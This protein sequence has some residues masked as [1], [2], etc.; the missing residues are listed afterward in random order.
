MC[1]ALLFAVEARAQVAVQDDSGRT[2][3]LECP[4]RRVIALYGAFNE[5]LAAMGLDDRIVART[6]ADR[7]PPSIVGKPTIGTHMRPNIERVLGYKPDLVLQMAG[8]KQAAEAA[9]ALNRFGVETAVF[10]VESFDDLFSI[11]KRVGI[12]L[13]AEEKA[14]A[15]VRTMRQRLDRVAAAV[16]RKSGPAPRVFFEV[17]YPNLLAAGQTSMVSDVIRRAGGSNCATGTDKLVRL[18]EE[19]L[20]RMD[21][22]VYLVQKGPM[23]PNP[24]PPST[25]PHYR[26]LSAVKAGRVFIVDEQA[27][28]RPGPRNVDAVE[29]LAGLLYPKIGAGGR[30]AEGKE[31]K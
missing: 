13:G 11:A 24:V 19:E 5:I 10:R 12:L 29:E 14:D 30:A 16:A 17:R 1:L 22:D 21:P 20:L 6:D 7:L 2:V 15:L 25:R 31:E 27:Y 18:G 8:R 26:T 3:R 28:S 4:A 23:N 9:S